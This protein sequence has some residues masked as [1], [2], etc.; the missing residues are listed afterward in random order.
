MD[1]KDIKLLRVGIAEQI[2]QPDIQNRL[3]DKQ[4][5]ALRALVADNLT[6]EQ[7]AHSYFKLPTG[8]GKT[9]MFSYMARAYFDAIA[10]NG[11]QRQK[12][13][14]IVP[15]LSLIKQTQKKL[16]EFA[17]IS[18]TEFSSRKKDNDCDVIITTYNSLGKLFGTVDFNDVGLIFADEAHHMLGDKIS[19]KL[20]FY[21]KYVPVIGFTATPEYASNRAVANMLSTQIYS[22]SISDGI[23][24]GVLCPAK[25][26]LYRSSVILDLATVPARQNGEYD[27]ENISGKIDPN[28]LADEIAQIYANGIDEDTGTEFKKLR[29]IIN[30]PNSKI[31]NAQA[32]AINRVMGRNVAVALHKVGISNNN[33][34]RAQED[35]I[36]G[37][38]SVACQV[39]TMTEGFDDPTVAMCI[40]Y[41]TRSRVR[42]EQT[43]GRAIRID[44]NNPNKI[45]FIVDTVFRG[46]PHERV[47]DIF[48]TA[49]NAQQV[50]FKDIA[51]DIFI[52]PEITDEYKAP[53]HG[54][55]QRKRNNI[56][57]E[58]FELIT[59]SATLIELNRK[60]NEQIANSIFDDKNDN[61]QTIQELKEDP[62]FPMSNFDKI[63]KKMEDLQPYMSDVIQ[64]RRTRNGRNA[65]CLYRGARKVFLQRAGYGYVPPKT[66]DWQTAN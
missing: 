6:D 55:T 27:Y 14:I 64:V 33:F 34:D 43:A 7:I 66:D 59:D 49:S 11:K 35:F 46:T 15:R 44:E 65:L 60:N 50:L 32:D 57:F 58:N 13:I 62:T 42:A 20:E 51:G 19:E 21:N 40:N 47:E 17:D 9:V 56:K 31:A 25:N 63:K 37:K 38:Y 52:Y 3:R 39:G 18:A 16:A 2:Q 4:I 53:L 36:A 48:Y 41:P 28:I 22:I 12:I 61:W 1:T 30:C 26:I 5:D 45:A 24:G 8:F 23:M 10:A 54:A 29:A